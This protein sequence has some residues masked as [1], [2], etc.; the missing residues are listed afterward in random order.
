MLLNL[1][2]IQRYL[3]NGSLLPGDLKGDLA[4]FTIHAGRAFIFAAESLDHS[5][6]P[7]I[8]IHRIV[9][10]PSDNQILQS[11][12]SGSRPEQIIHETAGLDKG[13]PVRP[14]PPGDGFDTEFAESDD[15]D[16][17]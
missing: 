14:I 6:S 10:T 7:A 16:A 4:R 12:E 9:K 3:N 5:R 11:P 15:M 2:V 13:P 8:G 1:Y 17:G